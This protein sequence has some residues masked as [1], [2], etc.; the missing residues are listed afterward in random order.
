MQ[1][2]PEGI[3]KIMDVAETYADPCGKK[4][5]KCNVCG[6]KILTADTQTHSAICKTTSSTSMCNLKEGIASM[7]EIDE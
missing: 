5:F 7:V 1:C 4:T 3:C 6:V 2:L